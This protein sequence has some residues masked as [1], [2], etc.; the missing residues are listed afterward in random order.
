MYIYIYIG[1]CFITYIVQLK[2][3]FRMYYKKT[4][5]ENN[6]LLYKLKVGAFRLITSEEKIHVSHKTYIDTV[7]SK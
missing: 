4:L 1:I 3:T 2:Y 5:S 7:L 6:R